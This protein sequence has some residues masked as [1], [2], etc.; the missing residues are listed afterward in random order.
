MQDLGFRLVSLGTLVH[1]AG[2]V[3]S[4]PDRISSNRAMIALSSVIHPRSR[5]P[6]TACSGSAP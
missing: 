4:D 2:L 1:L 6:V 5:V 3:S